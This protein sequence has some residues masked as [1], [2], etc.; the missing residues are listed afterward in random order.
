MAWGGGGDTG[1]RIRTW[2]LD[3]T[4]ASSAIDLGGD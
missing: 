4:L 2:G 1:F 3:V